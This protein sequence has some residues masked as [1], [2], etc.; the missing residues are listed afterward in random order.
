MPIY[1]RVSSNNAYNNNNIN[2][3]HSQIVEEQNN[4]VLEQA[5]I[6]NNRITNYVPQIRDRTTEGIYNQYIK[7]Y[8][9]QMLG[10]TNIMGYKDAQQ[11]ITT[12]DNLYKHNKN[13]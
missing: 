9:N 10:N 6:D 13:S 5:T 1:E 2:A 12:T 11:N 8:Q 4:N 7:P 3:L